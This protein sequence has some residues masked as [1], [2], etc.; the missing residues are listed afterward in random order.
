MPSP[1]PLFFA[2]DAPPATH[3]DKTV[4]EAGLPTQA[5]PTGEP[6]ASLPNLGPKSQAMLAAA[7]IADAAQL[8]ALGSVAAFAK[9]KAVHP[10]ASLNLLWALEGAL[11]GARWQDVAK[12]DRMSLLMQLEDMLQ[13]AG[14]ARAA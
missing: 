14:R 8:R 13:G 9:V 7:G 12:D 3:T 4:M 5:P 1:I 2:I 6:I 10:S 11:S